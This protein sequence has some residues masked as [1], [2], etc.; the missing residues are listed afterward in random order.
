MGEDGIREESPSAWSDLLG[1]GPT[2]LDTWGGSRGPGGDRGAR[3]G[4]RQVGTMRPL[5]NQGQRVCANEAAAATPATT[6]PVPNRVE[7]LAEEV[8]SAITHGLGLSGAVVAV[9]WA[10]A[11]HR[12][13]SGA[14][15]DL[16]WVYGSSLWV[17]YL[18]ST[19]YHSLAR[20]S[21]RPVLKVLDHSAIYILIAGT[22]TPIVPAIASGATSRAVLAFV[23]TCAIVGVGLSAVCHRH[24]TRLVKGLELGA[25]IG[26]GWLALGLL[27]NF[28]R[29]GHPWFVAYLVAGG[30]FYSAGTYFYGRRSLRFNHSYWHIA[31][32][33]GSALHFA[34]I[35]EL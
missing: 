10:A 20:T 7:S 28:W 12:F 16:F 21:A 29:F 14:G 5:G 8:A 27:G 15:M 19:L 17:L 6:L 26:L 22:Y 32:M 2:G 35:L 31:V 4:L 25:Y 3:A 18:C 34:A 24:R 9:L 1:V 13:A 23:W 33:A 30:I 11:R